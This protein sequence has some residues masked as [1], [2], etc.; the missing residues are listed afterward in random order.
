MVAEDVDLDGNLDLLMSGN[1]F[2]MEPLPAGTMP[3]WA[4]I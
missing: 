3:L 2:G 4:S 1:D